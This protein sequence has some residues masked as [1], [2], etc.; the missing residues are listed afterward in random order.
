LLLRRVIGHVKN[1]NWLAVG[2]DF[3][4]VVVG[5]VIGLQVQQWA[6]EQARKN[7]E[8]V[9]LQRL[10]DEVE[11]LIAT[12]TPIIEARVR[13]HTEMQSAVQAIFSDTDRELTED[14]CRGIAYNYFVSNP[15]DHLG[16]LL[17]LQS[18]GQ[19]SII[20]NA[21]VSAALQSYLLTRARARDSQSQIS[22][23]I[24]PL[25]PAYPELIQVELPTLAGDLEV[26]SGQFACDLSGMRVDHAFLQDLDIA[27][28][29]VAFHTF[30]NARVSASLDELH[31]VLQ[32]VLRISGSE[33]R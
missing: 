4:I 16:S 10:R 32:K 25:G 5:V 26:V 1:Q 17:E 8:M 15:T 30:D 24:K 9:Y 2:I 33:V 13:W 28:S 27:Q 22:A 7:Q 6:G 21:E 3:L 14:E 11:G 29:H 12:R 19:S 18:S 20:R 31:R 23:L